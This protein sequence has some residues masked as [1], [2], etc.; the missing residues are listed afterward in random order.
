[1]SSHNYGCR[2]SDEYAY[3]GLRTVILENELIRVVVLADKG[4]DI[5]EFLHKPSDIDFMWRGPRE[6]PDLRTYVPTSGLADGFF[7]D[8]Y[9]GAWQEIFPNGGPAATY[10]GAAIGQHGEVSLQPWSSRIVEDTID[11]VAVEFRVQTQRTPFILEKTLALERHQG[12][13]FMHEKLIN[14][15]DEPMEFMWGHHPAFGVPLLDEHCV[16]DTD[17]KTVVGDDQEHDPN[18]RIKLGATGRWPMIEDRQGN[19]IDISKVP[20]PKTCGVDV[21]YLTDFTEGWYA[22]TNTRKRVGFGMRWDP[23]LFKHVWFWQ[24]YGRSYGYPWFGRTY[25]M[26]LEPFTSYPGHGL[27]EVIRRGRQARIEANGVIE[28]DLVAVAYDGVER[29]KRIG[30]R[31]EIEQ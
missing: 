3:K 12:V 28:T 7:M 18:G 25:N 8:Y 22:L 27:E 13:L 19:Q 6:I 14:E 9:C 23:A 31:G 20:P 16:V 1:M 30:K 5:I 21:A 4:T 17:A 10:K 24:S 26:A 11:R 15:A 2:V 29:V